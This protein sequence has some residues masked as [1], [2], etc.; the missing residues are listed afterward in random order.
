[1]P[2]FIK[3]LILLFHF[4]LL[5]CQPTLQP[6]RENVAFKMFS[7]AVEQVE[8]KN[9]P[10]ALNFINK[11]IQANS[12]IAGY[13][14]LKGDILTKQDMLEEAIV[15]YK[16]AIKRRSFLPEA[17]LKIAHNYFVLKE[18]AKA[19]QDY[20][21]AFAQRPQQLAILLNLAECYMQQKEFTLAENTLGVYLSQIKKL[22]KKT[23]RYYYILSGKISFEKS[24]YQKV[25][26]NFEKASRLAPFNRNEAM[27]F[28]LALLKENQLETAYSSATRFLKDVLTASD[29]HALR[30]L[31]YFYQENYKDAITQLKLSI[32]K[33]TPL[34]EAYTTLEKIYLKE[35][36]MQKAN[37]ING[38][39]KLF[40]NRRL[41]NFAL[42]Y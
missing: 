23:E 32:K 35:N 19:I 21:K 37:E 11:A 29:I 14:E 4:Y 26:I 30:G 33:Q 31:Y 2:K 42:G 16:N 10:E 38:Q 13:F 8:A 39:G 28:V 24:T 15:Q 40:I 9:Y 34:Y 7:R 27:V 18:Y 5:S 20:K 12:R 3:F 36:N 22:N 1:M 17:F 41:I 6:Q 25:I